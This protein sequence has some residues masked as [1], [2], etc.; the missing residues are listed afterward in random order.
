MYWTVVL[1]KGPS[2]RF[3]TRWEARSKLKSDAQE[4]VSQSEARRS[5]DRLIN[6]GGEQRLLRFADELSK[7]ETRE[8]EDG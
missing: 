7:R 8:K 4:G 3:L 2:R 5:T 1:V 6:L